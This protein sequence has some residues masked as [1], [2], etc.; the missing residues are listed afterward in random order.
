MDDSRCL[1][2]LWTTADPLTAHNMVL[3]Y[4]TNAKLRGWWDSVTV[5]IWG[6]SAKYAAEDADIQTRMAVAVQAGVKFTACVACARNLGVHD[7]LAGLGV[8]VIP[9]G[10]PLSRLIAEKK[11]LITV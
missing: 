11:P 10:E 2:I 9:W 4:A 5:I 6:A 3:M 7:K 8:E 1:H